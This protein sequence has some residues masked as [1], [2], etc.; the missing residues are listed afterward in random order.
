MDVDP[1]KHNRTAWDRQV[2]AANRW[3]K[4]VDAAVIERARRG[5]V[6]VVL[7]PTRLVP[8]AWFPPLPGTATLC[9]AG[10][11]GQQSPVLAAAGAAVTVLD[12]SP[13]QLEQD[14]AVA[15]REGLRLETVE[16]DMADLSDFRDD[17]FELIFHP[18]SN[19]FVPAVLPVWRECY[20]VLRPGGLLLAGFT[21]P[22]RYIFDDERRENGNLEVRY[23][24]PYSDLEN[25][26]APHRRAIV[27]A[28]E[29]LEFGHTLEDQVGGQL[30]A[31]FLMSG[32]Y[33]DRYPPEDN[34][35]LSRF[36]AT[37]IAT[38]SQKPA[39]L[40]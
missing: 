26:P 17:S 31:G 7:T 40:P 8:A 34:D 2:E 36:M 12:N 38:R 33:E 1:R 32:F 25:L 5:Q 22:V 23:S 13:K 21:N 20:R 10:A 14:R 19:A 11:G 37:F 3:T 15:R 30:A 28:E 4:P 9:L 18:C 35:P 29:P 24:L 6:E 16:G 27:A 39:G